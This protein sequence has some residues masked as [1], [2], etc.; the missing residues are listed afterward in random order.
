M[1]TPSKSECWDGEEKS[2]LAAN[3]SVVIT[4]I[5]KKEWEVSMPPPLMESGG[6]G[7]A[8]L[9]KEAVRRAWWQGIAG[10]PT[11][12]GSCGRKVSVPLL[13]RALGNKGAASVMPCFNPTNSSYTLGQK[14][15][16]WKLEGHRVSIP[17]GSL[18]A[19]DSRTLRCCLAD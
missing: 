18:F 12:I 15:S 5:R 3:T 4:L 10:P 13:W 11:L 14:D 6:M 19:D 9:W 8:L 7:G 1:Q 2:P 17:G 16:L